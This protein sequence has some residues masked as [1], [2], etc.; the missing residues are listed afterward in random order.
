MIVCT[1]VTSS[2]Q[3]VYKHGLNQD[4]LFKV[5]LFII[6]GL[7]LYGIGAL[8]LTIALKGGDLSVLYPIIALSYVFVNIGSR[9]FFNEDITV[10]K[11]IGIIVIILGVSIIGYGG[12]RK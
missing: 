4:I 5:F 6:L 1:L 9:L 2:A 12:N 3:L 11:W 8:L 7:A 10:L